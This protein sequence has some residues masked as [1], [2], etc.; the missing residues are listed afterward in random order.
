MLGF[1]HFKPEFVDIK[2]SISKFS[3]SISWSL[4][5]QLLLI[6]IA[7]LILCLFLALSVRKLDAEELKNELRCYAD[8]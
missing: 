6:T 3:S 4:W 1:Y 5:V 2:A 7:C 8:Q